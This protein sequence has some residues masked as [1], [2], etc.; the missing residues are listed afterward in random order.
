M[1][2][3]DEQRRT[4]LLRSHHLAGDAPSPLNAAEDV[5]VLHATDP[6][7]V[8]LSILARCE[9]ASVSGIAQAM[10][11]DRVLVRMLAMRRTMFVVP[12]DLVPVIHAAASMDVAA[13][14]R[15]Q[16]LKQLATLP[17]EPDLPEDVEGWLAHVEAGVEAALERRGTATGAEL[18]ADEPRLRTA[19]LPTS[20]R[21]WDVRRTITSQVLTMMGAEGRIV[22]CEPRG[23]W[24]SRHHTWQPG[25]Q[26]WPDGIVELDPA[27]ARRQLVSAYLRRFGP[28][29]ETD[30]AW[31]TGWALGV[32]RKTLAAL[33]TV[34]AELESGTGIM[35]A[36]DAELPVPGS[37]DDVA[38]LL[39]ALDP[40]P[41]GWKER[42]WFLPE[43][44]SPLFDRNGNI[45][46]TVW[47]N[48]EIVGGW[49]VR[50]DGSI[51][52][53]ILADRGAAARAAIDAAAGKLEPRLGDTIVVP[54]F[55][56]PLERELSSP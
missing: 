33:D 32:T 47:W 2:M 39:P 54:S 24:T 31:W 21:A 19:F 27:L 50:P 5:V 16:L 28:A 18:G 42:S 9:S 52:T 41:M 45:G 40:T 8:Y 4:R 37:D 35:L 38:T 29:T 6:A 26:W 55:R 56:T 34:E 11:D 48:G 14:I 12:A 36:S 22:R 13:R 15:K 49:A 23:S 30:V 1:R 46:P 53:R 10:Y 20:D 51:T 44:P 43:D 25:T 3:T 17:T 7:T